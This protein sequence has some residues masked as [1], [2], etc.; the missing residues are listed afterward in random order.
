MAQPPS[1]R[2]GA[3]LNPRVVPLQRVPPFSNRRG[4]A[5][6]LPRFEQA[7]FPDCNGGDGQPA[8]CQSLFDQRS[9]FASEALVFRRHP[10]ECVSVQNNH[11]N[12]F[13]SDVP[14]GEMMSP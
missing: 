6:P 13:Q 9:R 14:I 8:L 5:H 7:N 1:G 3:F 12:A 4:Q 2:I 10:D 11:F